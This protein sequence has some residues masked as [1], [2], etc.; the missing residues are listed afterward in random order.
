MNFR[1]NQ[2]LK[3][4][5]QKL[6]RV[7]TVEWDNVCESAML[8]NEDNLNHVKQQQKVVNEL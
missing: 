3:K 2:N 7:V 1:G 5:K 8:Y 4:K 6:F